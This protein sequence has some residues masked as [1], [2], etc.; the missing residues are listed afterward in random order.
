MGVQGH[1]IQGAKMY[2]GRLRKLNAN[3]RAIRF[4]GWLLFGVSRLKRRRD[5]VI[6]RWYCCHANKINRCQVWNVRG[7]RLRCKQTAMAEGHINRHV[8]HRVA[9]RLL[10]LRRQANP[11]DSAA[12]ENER[13]RRSHWKQAH[14]VEHVKRCAK[15]ILYG[16][17]LVLDWLDIKIRHFL[18]SK[19]APNEASV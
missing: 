11:V 9:D 12:A 14:T 1:T 18:P 4:L 10:N 16:R 7:Q 19:W 2:R 6:F 17:W 3:K 5:S 13:V 15:W 8:G